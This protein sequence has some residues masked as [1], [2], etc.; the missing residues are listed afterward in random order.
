MFERVGKIAHRVV[1]QKDFQK[2]ADSAHVCFRAQKIINELFPQ[3]ASKIDVASFSN[4]VLKIISPHPAINQEIQFK[5]DQIIQN[6]NQKLKS[7]LVKDLRF[8]I[9]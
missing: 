6:L 3:L 9:K 5:K 4:G 7:D 2:T 1:V 8:N